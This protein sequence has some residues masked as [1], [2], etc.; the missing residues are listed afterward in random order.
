MIGGLGDVGGGVEQMRA[1]R[2]MRLEQAEWRG[3]KRLQAYW[4]GAVCLLEGLILPIEFLLAFRKYL[5]QGASWESR[6]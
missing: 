5:S 4:G 3:G 6:A 2:K 1:A